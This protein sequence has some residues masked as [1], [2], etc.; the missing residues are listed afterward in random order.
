MPHRLEAGA[1]LARTQQQQQGLS[2]MRRV[3]MAV[4]IEAAVLEAEAAAAR[5]VLRRSTGSPESGPQVYPHQQDEEASEH[6][7]AVPGSGQVAADAQTEASLKLAQEQLREAQAALARM[8]AERGAAVADCDVARAACRTAQLQLRRLGSVERERDTLME[9]AAQLQVG[10][11][12]SLLP[13]FACPVPA[14][15]LRNSACGTTAHRRRLR[16][17]SPATGGARRGGGGE[18]DDEPAACSV[19]RRL[20]GRPAGP[21]RRAAGSAARG[22]GARGGGGGG[23]VLGASGGLETMQSIGDALLDDERSDLI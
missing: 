18:R 17:P 9:M 4:S 5:L 20:R 15:Q 19:R 8:Y 3:S 23:L 22:G 16:R 10:A 14:R 7:A 21:G 13:L 12:G 11:R 2:E 1:R 6:A